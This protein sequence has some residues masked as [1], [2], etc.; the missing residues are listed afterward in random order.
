MRGRILVYDYDSKIKSFKFVGT[1]NYADY[2]DNPQ[3][4]GIE[5]N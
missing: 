4:Y 1:F 2:F 5:N 3:K